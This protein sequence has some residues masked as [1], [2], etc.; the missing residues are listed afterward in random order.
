[1]FSFDSTVR[2]RYADTDQMHVVYHAKYIEYF[3]SGRTEAIRSL[4]VTYKQI[5]E[6][7]LIMP[8]VRVQCDYLRPGLY[9]DLLTVRTI[10]RAIP[11]DH[12]I[13]FEQEIYN[14]AEKLICKGK[15]LLYFLDRQTQSKI[16]MPDHLAEKFKPFFP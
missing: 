8:V 10:L 7:G 2:V 6:W 15:I 5:E 9:D 14:E 1:M 11:L 4:G 13:E 16:A 3:E 12:L